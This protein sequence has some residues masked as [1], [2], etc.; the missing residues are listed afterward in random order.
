MHVKLVCEQIHA[1]AQAKW[2]AKDE[3]KAAKA[4]VMVACQNNQCHMNIFAEPKPIEPEVGYK[5]IEV[6]LA[7]ALFPL[8]IVFDFYWHQPCNRGFKSPNICTFFERF[9]H[10]ENSAM[11]KRFFDISVQ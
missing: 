10:K 1:E 4:Q 5:I 6:W 9:Y 8:F 2:D 7:R 11:Q 3:Q